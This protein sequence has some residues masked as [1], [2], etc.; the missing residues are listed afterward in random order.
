V[1]V[2]DEPGAV[3]KGED[4]AVG[5]EGGEGAGEGAAGEAVGAVKDGK[6]TARRCEEERRVAPAKY[7]GGRVVRGGSE[8][9]RR[10]TASCG[11]SEWEGR[12][13]APWRVGVQEGKGGG[14]WW[15][16]CVMGRAAPDSAAVGV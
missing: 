16:E 13:A 11:R 12:R 1:S 4:S 15:R 5:E 3:R 10:G 14:R 6:L 9:E 2:R 8:E 7:G